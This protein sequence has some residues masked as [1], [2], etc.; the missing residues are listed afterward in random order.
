MPSKTFIRSARFAADVRRAE[1]FGF[2]PT[3]LDFKD[4]AFAVKIRLSIKNNTE[5]DLYLV[6]TSFLH[7]YKLDIRNKKGESVKPTERGKRLLMGAMFITGRRSVKVSPG[8]SR[9]DE[10]V[11]NEI[12]NMNSR[13]TYSI[14]ASRYVPMSKNKGSEK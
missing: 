3:S 9:E 6:E 12:Y 10:F 5:K 11:I 13:G 8:E 7:K 2:A 4:G 14:T 1:V